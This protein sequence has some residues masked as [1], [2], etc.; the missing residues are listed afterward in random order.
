M[1]IRQNHWTYRIE[2]LKRGDNSLKS[3]K[4]MMRKK[5]KPLSKPGKGDNSMS[6][7]S[8]LMVIQCIHG[9]YILWY[10]ASHAKYLLQMYFES[11]RHF[12]RT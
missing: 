3:D 8:F 4:I 11:S 7:L 9:N 2:P 6:Y 10:H 5:W 1:K 12:V